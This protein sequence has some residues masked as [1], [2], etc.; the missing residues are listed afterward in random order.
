MADNRQAKPLPYFSTD[1]EAEAFVDNADLTQYDLS[2][3]TRL[4]EFE[5]NKKSARI[6]LRVPESLI[7]A[8][9]AR[10]KERN[11]PYQRLIREAIEKS[12]R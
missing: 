10:A 6:N 5:F 4:S 11:M 2:G 7:S 12:L 9:K 3:G 1:D 8:V